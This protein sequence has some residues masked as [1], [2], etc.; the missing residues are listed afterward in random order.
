MAKTYKNLYDKICSFENLLLAAKK[1]Q[2][3]KRFKENT[4]RL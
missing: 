1:T 2:K 3:G 4:A